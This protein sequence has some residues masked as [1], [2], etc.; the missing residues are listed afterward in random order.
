MQAAH[1]GFCASACEVQ[2]LQTDAQGSLLPPLL[3]PLPPLLLGTPLPLL[4][5][6]CAAVAL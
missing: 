5:A 3:P 4:V 2:P 6:L 1:S